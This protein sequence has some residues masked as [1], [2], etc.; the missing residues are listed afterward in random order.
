[1]DY[2]KE[3][4]SEFLVRLLREKEVAT[5]FR[6][7]RHDDWNDNYELYRNKVR[8]NRLTQRQAVNIP[9]MKETIKTLLSKI[10]ETPNIEWKELGGDRQKEIYLQSVWDDEMEKGNWEAVDIQDKKTAMMYG[11]PFKKFN[12]DNGKVVLSALDVFD[13][14]I[15][16]LTN[17]I[18]IETARYIIHEN[19][20]RSVREV[21]ADSRYDDDAK[22]KLKTYLSTR[23]AMIASEKNKE[24]W[25]SKMERLEAMGVNEG[26]FDT[27]AAG[28][29]VL[30]LTE[31]FT[32]MWDGKKW[33]RYVAVYANSE[34]LLLKEPLKDLIGVELW[35]FTTWT[36]DLETVDFWNDSIA[37]LVRVPNKLL[38]VWLSQMT[39]N[40]TLK[41]F[42]M[43]WYDATK[44]NYQPQTYEP[45]PG[46]MLP[47]P[48]NPSDVLLPVQV[49]G[50]ED[51]LEQIN[52]LTNMIER[53]T[54]AT[55]TEK[56]EMESKQVRVA[57][58]EMAV[59]KAMER[60]LSMAKFYRRGW[61]DTANKWLKIK[62]ANG[63]EKTTLHK[64][65]SDG[66]MYAKDISSKDWKSEKG[67]KPIVRSTSEQ[68]NESIKALQ[69]WMFARQQFPQ[70]MALQKISQR[71]ILDV[72]NLTPEEMRQI[73]EAENQQPQ[74]PIQI[75]QPMA[76]PADESALA[77]Q[78]AQKAN[79]VAQMAQTI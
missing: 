15:D 7:R 44:E 40:R 53:A 58:I 27:F 50:L 70:N 63:G 31:H 19:I 30:N 8:I 13:V 46:R 23:E 76:Q 54:G 43:H 32:N 25:E 9:I 42:Q 69:K 79:D 77:G 22:R 57:E 52:F 10:D 45:G 49:S 33:T 1:M 41:N 18:D 6:K 68:E 65:G 4:K 28:D 55:A 3:L 48:G 12:I 34:V 39:E 47:A 17:P 62:E 67:Y 61:Y 59:G 2:I 24:A 35:P 60:T 73:E 75:P 5:N 20:F 72:L 38:N 16:P 36:D 26:D 37:D 66:A 29:A 11:R 56:G 74:M 21:L 64:L 71:R 78:V 51:C 14:K